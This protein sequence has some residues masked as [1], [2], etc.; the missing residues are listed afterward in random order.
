MTGEEFLRAGVGGYFQ[1]AYLLQKNAPIGQLGVHTYQKDS[2]LLGV[3]PNPFWVLEEE[4]R[5]EFWVDLGSIQSRNLHL[6]WK[7]TSTFTGQCTFLFSGPFLTWV[8]DIFLGFTQLV[9][10]AQVLS[11]HLTRFTQFQIIN[12]MAQSVFLV[13]I[14]Y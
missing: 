2:S 6:N 14:V 9:W 10:Q 4:S 7:P 11:F 8:R 5:V 13:L 3:E 1:Q 12:R